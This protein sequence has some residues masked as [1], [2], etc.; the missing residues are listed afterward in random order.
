MDGLFYRAP[1]NLYADD[2]SDGHDNEDGNDNDEGHDN[3]DDA[4]QGLS[5]RGPMIDAMTNMDNKLTDTKKVKEFQQCKR[6]KSANKIN[7][8]NL[9]NSVF[10][11]ETK[12]MK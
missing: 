12:S 7:S 4:I 3:E 5:Y 9:A 8:Y 6:L 10:K 1:E 2:G 11:S